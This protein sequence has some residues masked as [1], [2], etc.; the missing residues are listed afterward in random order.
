MLQH[1]MQH[2]CTHRNPGCSS[3]VQIKSTAQQ[4]AAHCDV[5]LIGRIAYLNN[6]YM[7]ETELSSCLRSCCLPKIAPHKQR[8]RRVC[9]PRY[10]KNSVHRSRI[11]SNANEMMKC[12]LLCSPQHTVLGKEGCLRETGLLLDVLYQPDPRLTPRNQLGLRGART[13]TSVEARRWSS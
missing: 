2:K 1:V 7:R 6:R 11:N 12:A 13:R 10:I 3:Q 4:R 8:A 5:L 9:P